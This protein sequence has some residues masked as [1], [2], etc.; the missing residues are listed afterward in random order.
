MTTSCHFRREELEEYKRIVNNRLTEIEKK[1]SDYKNEIDAKFVELG[2]QIETS[3][4]KLTDEM[5]AS[6]TNQIAELKNVDENQIKEFETKMNRLHSD[7]GTWEQAAKDEITKLQNLM[8]E[9]KEDR[10]KERKRV[11]EKLETLTSEIR[12]ALTIIT[13]SASQQN[14]PDQG[15]S[16]GMES[17]KQGNP[18]TKKSQGAQGTRENQAKQGAPVTQRTQG[19]PRIQEKPGA[20]EK[21]R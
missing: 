20:P 8:E 9:E 5:I 13:I 6:F 14:K 18:E 11:D 17:K 1:V 3:Q 4:K 15:D 7:M 10:R 21:E 16:S 12:K 2:C 19:A